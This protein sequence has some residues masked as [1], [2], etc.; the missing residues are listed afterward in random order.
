MTL[1]QAIRQM[2]VYFDQHG[3]PLDV[4]YNKLTDRA[5]LSPE[6]YG[7]SWTVIEIERHQAILSATY[8]KGLPMNAFRTYWMRYALN[9]ITGEV[10]ELAE[11]TGPLDID[12]SGLVDEELRNGFY[13]EIKPLGDGKYWIRDCSDDRENEISNVEEAKE[14]ALANMQV[15]SNYFKESLQREE[16]IAREQ[17]DQLVSEYEEALQEQVTEKVQ[18]VWEEREEV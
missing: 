17:I 12:V 16:G 2:K 9:P 3:W 15:W 14:F 11:K 8:T 5:S 13:L 1:D 4:S 18:Q 6:T 7:P 10:E